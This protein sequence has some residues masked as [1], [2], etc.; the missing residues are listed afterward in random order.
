MDT[1]S[2]PT[3]VGGEQA[4]VLTLQE[5]AGRLGVHY[6]TA[7]R[8]VRLGLL[9]ATKAGAAWRVVAAD[10]DRLVAG[11]G[12]VAKG[13]GRQDPAPWAERLQRRPVSG[14]EGGAWGGVEAAAAPG[15]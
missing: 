10:V 14:G 8:Y 7:Y 2:D 5:A 12:P 11:D 4:E 1:D 3:G 6:M 15:A 13:R 9:P